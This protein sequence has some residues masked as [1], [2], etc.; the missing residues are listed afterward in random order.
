MLPP[1]SPWPMF[2]AD[3]GARATWLETLRQWHASACHDAKLWPWRQDLQ[4]V[5]VR[6]ERV[7]AAYQ[8]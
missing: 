5:A 8:A 1:L 2:E 7:I 6:L 3:P 4:A